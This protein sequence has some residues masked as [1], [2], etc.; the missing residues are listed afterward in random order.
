M[1]I[2][3]RLRSFT[4]NNANIIAQDRLTG[5]LIEEKMAAYVRLGIRLLYRGGGG[6]DSKRSMHFNIAF[7]L[8]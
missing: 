3:E 4:Q 7:I 2:F 8:S 5:Q 1:Y 6:V